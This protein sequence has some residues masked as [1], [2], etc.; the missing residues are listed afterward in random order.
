MHTYVMTIESHLVEGGCGV[1]GDVDEVGGNIDG[2][3]GAAAGLFDG[4]PSG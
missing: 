4:G 1:G 3:V 2:G